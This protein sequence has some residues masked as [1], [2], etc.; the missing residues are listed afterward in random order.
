MTISAYETERGEI[1]V[2]TPYTEAFVNDCRASGGRWDAGEKV[3]L[4]GGAARQMVR[5]LVVRHFAFD[6]DATGE[7][8]WIE[9][10]ANRE[11]YAERGPVIV[12]GKVIAQAFGRDSGARVGDDVTMTGGRIR[13]DGSRQY[14]H[15]TIDE[16][17]SFVFRAPKG[18]V[19]RL[20]TGWDG[21]V[22]DIDGNLASLRA[23]L[24]ALAVEASRI[25]ARR[26]EIEARI[27]AVRTSEIVDRTVDAA[28]RRTAQ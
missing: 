15:T 28:S 26:A 18:S 1:A 16:G 12:A 4:F 11:V 20:P 7:M 22:C 2:Q 25:A 19:D 17:S 10:V 23:E 3:W 24:A 9:I 8:E 21:T 27:E 6:I 5:E 13:S 14:W